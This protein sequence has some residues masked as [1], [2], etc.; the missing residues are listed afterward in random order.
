M[1]ENY[2]ITFGHEG[3]PCTE[4]NRGTGLNEIEDCNCC[5]NTGY[6]SPEWFLNHSVLEIKYIVSSDFKYLSSILTLS[7]GGPNIYLNLSDTSARLKGYWG[8]DEKETLDLEQTEFLRHLDFCLLENF[9]SL[10]CNN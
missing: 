5:Y 1:L 8:G 10:R 9:E 2:S 6:I 3:E 4:C 7:Y